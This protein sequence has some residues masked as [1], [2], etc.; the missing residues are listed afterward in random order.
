MHVRNST[1]VAFSTHRCEL[2]ST[3]VGDYDE[4]IRKMEAIDAKADRYRE[5]HNNFRELTSE[6]KR[7]NPK[8]QASRLIR[9]FPS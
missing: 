8:L 7:D 9:R 5:I 6:E 2:L 4:A 1:S 3:N